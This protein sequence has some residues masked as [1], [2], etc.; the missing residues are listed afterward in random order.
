M[1]SAR[2]IPTRPKHRPSSPPVALL[3]LERGGAALQL[4][5]VLA[6]SG[7]G[8]SETWIVAQQRDESPGDLALRV[9]RKLLKLEREGRA[10][11]SSTLL[12]GAHLGAEWQSA[13][14]A[15]LR[16]AAQLAAPSRPSTPDPRH[17]EHAAHEWAPTARRVAPR[18]DGRFAGRVPQGVRA[19]RPT[20]PPADLH[21]AP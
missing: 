7:G 15:I 5:E 19:S 9:I 10:L 20:A 14:A 2:V 3:V 17:A 1:D 8:A 21:A 4:A 18:K 12:R 6:E 16:M 13:R 11:V